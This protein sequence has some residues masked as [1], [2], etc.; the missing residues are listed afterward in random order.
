MAQTRLTMPVISV[1]AAK[2]G[3][4]KTTLTA[5][6]ALAFAESG[7]NVLAIDLDPQNALRFHLAEDLRAAESGLAEAAAGSRNW[8]QVMQRGRAG[9]VLLPFGDV[10]DDVQIAFEGHLAAHPGWLSD[11]LA[12][13]DLPPGTIVL[14]D[15]PPG[16]SVFLQ[17]ALRASHVG[18]VTLLADAG[19]FAT[20]STVDRMVDKHCRPRADFIGCTYVVNQADASRR[21]NRDVL[22]ALRAE[23]GDS[24]LG[25]VHQDQ[26]VCEALASA[27][28][29]RRYAPHAQAAEDFA[30]IAARLLARLGT[31]PAPSF[32]KAFS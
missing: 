20:R 23:L 8:R 22:Q 13:F 4:G 14:V 24:L 16:N 26:A 32:A 31:T 2:G 11:T 19:S 17:Q 1:I 25:V 28:P 7:R 18:I 27:L 30:Q 12:G 9:V 3:V 10:D 15:T 21:L 6:L 29:V 5:N